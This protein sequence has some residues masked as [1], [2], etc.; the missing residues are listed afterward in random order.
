MDGGFHGMG[1][2]AFAAV[3]GFA[4][5]VGTATGASGRRGSET[6]AEIRIHGNYSVADE[7]IM[8]LADIAVG[9]AAESWVLDAAVDRLRASEASG[10]FETVEVR[11]RYRSLTAREEVAVVIVVREKPRGWLADRLMFA[12]ILGYEEGY[13]FSYGMQFGFVDVPWRGGQFSV[14][15]TWGAERG[16]ALEMESA[17]GNRWQGRLRGGASAS[18]RMHPHF[19]I[20]DDRLRLW[21]GLDA[22]LASG[23]RMDVEVGKEEVVF[24]DSSDWLTRMM[25]GL[26]YRS[27]WS[28]FPRDDVKLRAALERLSI[29]G[30]GAAVFRPRVDVQGFKGAGGQA[31]LAARV[32]YSGASAGL[33]LYERSLLGGAGT[34]RG[35]RAGVQV[36]DHMVATSIELRVPLN[37]ALAADKTGFRIF[38]DAATAWNAGSTM[39][40]LLEGVGV[41]V[42]VAVPLV[43]SVLVDV[44]HDLRDGV[45]VHWTGGFGF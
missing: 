37:S 27:T 18:R 38:Y 34:L 13:G 35:W 12:P 11:K 44:G 19:G 42:F 39:G 10:R 43:G 17:F 31:V 1:K 5:L 22:T 14:P 33:A 16:T 26:E 30:Q 41:G 21:G 9:D 36:G 28:E 4:L 40:R 20:E 6:I 24:G 7:E 23:L 29:D 32:L 25:V 2:W 45:V 3:L 8:T 15:M